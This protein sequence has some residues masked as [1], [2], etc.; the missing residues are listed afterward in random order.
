MEKDQARFC[1]VP[2]SGQKE[3][4][5]Q[6]ITLAFNVSLETALG[7]PQTAIMARLTVYDAIHALNGN[8]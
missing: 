3:I 7:Y 5:R 2:D 1:M 4:D 6:M 8:P